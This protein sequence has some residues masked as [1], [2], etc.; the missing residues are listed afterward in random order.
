VLEAELAYPTGDE[1]RDRCRR[2]NEGMLIAPP[3]S[4]EA[5]TVSFPMGSS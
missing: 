4:F 1:V 3:P 2:F 5:V